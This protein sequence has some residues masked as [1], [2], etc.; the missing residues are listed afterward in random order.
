MHEGQEGEMF[1]MLKFSYGAT[2]TIYNYESY[3][4]VAVF[5][6]CLHSGLR[7]SEVLL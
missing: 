2:C 5:R 1:G 3:I 7:Y 4:F 6:W